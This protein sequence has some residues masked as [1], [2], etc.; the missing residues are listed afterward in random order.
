MKQ[1]DESL[2][3]KEK[4]LNLKHAR[5]KQQQATLS[6]KKQCRP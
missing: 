5:K 2:Y 1:H 4:S 6:A 3:Q